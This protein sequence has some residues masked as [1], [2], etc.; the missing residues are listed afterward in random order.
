MR[1]GAPKNIM[2]STDECVY[3]LHHLHV[4]PCKIE[5]LT[6]CFLLLVKLCHHL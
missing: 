2:G 3:E 4:D 5:D 1:D 6:L